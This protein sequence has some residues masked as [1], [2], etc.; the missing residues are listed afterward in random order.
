MGEARTTSP[1]TG[2]PAVVATR[3]EFWDETVC[4]EVYAAGA[5]PEQAFAH[6][7]EERYRLI[8]IL[9][10]F[11]RFHEGR[12]KDVLEIG[13]GFGS[14]HCEWARSGPRALTGVDLAPR[15]LGFTGERLKLLGL[16]STLQQADATSLP[17]EHGSFDLVYSW[18]VLHHTAHP[19]R[20]IEEVRRV[21]RPGGVARIMIYHL[22][23]VAAALLW[24][25]FGLLAGR[26]ARS[27][28]D[29]VAHHLESPGTQAFTVREARQLFRSFRSA[30]VRVEL[31][32]GDLLD[33][34]IGRHH[35]SRLLP[36][37][38]A[39]WPRWFVRTALRRQGLCLLIEARA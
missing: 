14:D 21:L 4:G 38:R 29:V 13:V 34:D 24:L 15:A 37:A 8:P 36:L 35:G 17:F 16:H 9:Q 23:S 26:P 33:G 7:A 2:G 12:G 20:A 32:Q 28:R 11:A 22:H 5:T 3:P 6:Q 30:E 27:W 19:A 18:G 25:R 10:P 39:V 31:S 1:G